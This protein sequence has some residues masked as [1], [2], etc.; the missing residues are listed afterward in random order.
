MMAPHLQNGASNNTLDH[1]GRRVDASKMFSTNFKALLIS[2]TVWAGDVELC[3]SILSTM[4]GSM[5]SEILSEL[6]E[7]LMANFAKFQQL[8]T[9][10]LCQMETVTDVWQCLS[11]YLDADSQ[12]TQLFDWSKAVLGSVVLS[13]SLMAA[14]DA[15]TLVSMSQRYGLDFY[16][17][18]YVRQI[19][20]RMPVG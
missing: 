7:P 18:W 12:N 9:D 8:L 5:S 13:K 19:L 16:N 2:C 3:K 20:Q 10:M 14:A 15:R 17:A 1:Y 11:R 6:Q 4:K